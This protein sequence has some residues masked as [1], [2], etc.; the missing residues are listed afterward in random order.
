MS[1]I[2]AVIFDIGGVVCDSPLHA[3]N[4]FEAAHGLQHNALN[5][6]IAA[7]GPQGAWSRLERGVLDPDSFVEPFTADLK[8][9][10]FDVD[11][12]AL[13]EAIRSASEPRP[14][15]LRAIE[16]IRGHGLGVAALTNN[17]R[18]D[19]DEH[20]L[21]AL[22]DEVIESSKTGV[23]KPDPAIY[24]LACEALEIEFSQAAFLDDIG[25]NLKAARALGMATIKVD[26]PEQAL[27]EL[28]ALLSLPLRA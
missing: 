24:R 1:A 15:M 11:G 13:F 3:I 21:Q 17:W 2:S 12:N 14:I 7:S 5:R 27:R 9:A 4:R 10:G 20:P 23:R 25:A 28:E 22:F 16:R 19:D 18:E 8:A 26:D 6:A